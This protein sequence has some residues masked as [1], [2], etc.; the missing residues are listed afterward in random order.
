MRP[1]WLIKGYSYCLKTTA[2][3]VGD[4]DYSIDYIWV[5]VTTNVAYVLSSIT[6]GVASWVVKA[7]DSIIN[8]GQRGEIRVIGET[9]M[10]DVVRTSGAGAEL[11]ANAI[12]SDP[13]AGEYKITGIKVD[14]NMK[15]VVTHDGSPA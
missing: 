6:S 11:P 12:I 1:N 14:A 5:N 9:A 10:G 15:V 2:P 4:A 3:G 13:G 8:E 7:P